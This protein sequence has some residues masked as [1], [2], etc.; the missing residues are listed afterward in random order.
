MRDRGVLVTG[1]GSGI[2]RAVVLMCAERGAKVAVLDI[3][4]DRA[5]L[6][7]EEAKELG[8]PAAIGVQCDVGAE[9]EVE[10]SFERCSTEIGTPYG[11]FA[12]AGVEV[13][14]MEHEL[15]YETWNKVLITNLSGVFLTCKH[16]LRHMLNADSGGSIVCA[17]SPAAFVGFSG[18]GNGAYAASKGGVSALVRALALDY[19]PRGI[20]VNAIVPGATDTSMMWASC[21]AEERECVREDVKEKAKREVPLGR[22]AQPEEPARAVLWLLS[23]DS[24]Y[25]TGSQLVCDGG[26]LAKSPNTF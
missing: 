7:A 9:G 24:S 26:L 13:N 2:G 5:S 8:S 4:E 15:P 10:H 12:S 18:G 20:R 25:V 23:D 14:G 17:S 19:A 11:V 3:D 21:S 6:A 22:L 1:G 16:A